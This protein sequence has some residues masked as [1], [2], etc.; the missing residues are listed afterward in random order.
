M[1]VRVRIPFMP[2]SSQARPLQDA[3][4]DTAQAMGASDHF[5][6]NMMSYFLENVAA[7]V[8]KGTVVRIPGF[9]I[10]TAYGYTPRKPG[11]D[12]YCLPSFKDLPVLSLA[13]P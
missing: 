7:Q 5:T 10:F 9:G 13:I 3:I 12:H 2:K 6:A 11:L 4:H 1:S 8:S